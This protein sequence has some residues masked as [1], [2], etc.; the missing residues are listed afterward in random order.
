MESVCV[1]LF[2]FLQSFTLVYADH[3]HYDFSNGRDSL[4]Y[5]NS[6]HVDSTFNASNTIDIKCPNNVKGNK[7]R[8]YPGPSDNYMISLE[9]ACNDKKCFKIPHIVSMSDLLGTVSESVVSWPEA[10]KDVTQVRLAPPDDG[11][12]VSRKFR[13]FRFFCMKDGLDIHGQIRYLKKEIERELMPKLATNLR[14]RDAIKKYEPNDPIGT[15]DIYLAANSVTH[16]CGDIVTNLF[17]NSDSKIK[18]GDIFDCAIDIEKYPDVGF[19]CT[20]KFDPPECFRRMYTSNSPGTLNS[21]THNAIHDKRKPLRT[22][23]ALRKYMNGTFSSTYCRCLDPVTKDVR[24]MITLFYS[25]DHT[26]D[27][28]EMLNENGYKPYFNEWCKV[29]FKPGNT[30]RITFPPENL[31]LDPNT[32]NVI[33]NEYMNKQ[34][35]SLFS[36]SDVKKSVF[37]RRK[38]GRAARRSTYDIVEITDFFGNN[39][40]EVDDSKRKD[41]IVTIKY[42]ISDSK[43]TAVDFH[44]LQYTWFKLCPYNPDENITATIS[45]IIVPTNVT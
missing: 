10:G 23:T 26:C 7:Y 11:I 5:G 21:I 42:N 41:G 36:P 24:A 44:Y 4:K 30:L 38:S 15:A 12:L 9:L 20:G 13:D 1:F 19:Y 2:L 8:L 3:Q 31:L 40:F 28:T 16:G 35:V 34:C 33:L 14:L 37:A 22:V 25:P 29:V 39:V 17:L 6:K 43:K 45:V 32:H 18:K 27:I